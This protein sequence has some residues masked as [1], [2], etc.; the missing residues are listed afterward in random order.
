[1][2]P[3][4]L[5]GIARLAVATLVAA[6]GLVGL[7]GGPA[8]AATCSGHGVN[9]VVDY[10]GLGGG[11]QKA[12]DPSGA[13]KTAN[14]VFPAAG[15]S[16]TYAQR[17]PG[18]VCRVNGRPS[19]DPCVNTS[20]SNAYWGLYWSDGKSGTW[21][22]ASQGVGGVSVPDGGFV[23]FSWQ[24][25]GANDP[26]GAS[27]VAA[28]PTP[29]ST[30][31]PTPKPK[32]TT[33]PTSKPKPTTKATATTTTKASS[34]SPS[35]TVRA[36]TSPSAKARTS[37]SASPTAS[38]SASSPASVAPPTAS[39]SASPDA[40]APTTTQLAASHPDTGGL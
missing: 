3:V 39:D 2:T 36:S 19:N 18:F 29:T 31:R 28:K 23:A 34:A 24:N 20:P 35:A 8:S 1:M 12:C 16:L 30:P 22:Y 10:H 13:G 40:A 6:A 9:V 15:F 17:Q 25:G 11:V 7:S 21:H 14:K 26:P 38:A 37:A 5:R 27:P 33:K 32:P 4:P